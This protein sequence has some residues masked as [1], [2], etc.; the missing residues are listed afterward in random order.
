MQQPGA[1][2]VGTT[3]VPLARASAGADLI[4]FLPAG[5]QRRELRD[6]HSLLLF[7]SILGCLS[8]CRVRSFKGGSSL[9]KA[10]GLIDRFSEDVDQ[11]RMPMSSPS[12]TSRP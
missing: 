5:H 1:A 12:T 2:V 11:P 7:L 4:A 10:H 9:S 8:D 3:S 6:P